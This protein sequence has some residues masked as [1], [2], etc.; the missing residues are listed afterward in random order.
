MSLE[1]SRRNGAY[2]SVIYSAQDGLEIARREKDTT[3]IFLG[4][5]FETTTPATALALKSA[6]AIGLKNFLVFSAHKVILPA[7]QV[8]LDDRE[9]AIDGFIAPGHVSVIIGSNAYHSIAA[10]YHRPCVAAGFDGQQMLLAMVEILVQLLNHQPKVESVYQDRIQPEGNIP[11][12]KIMDECFVSADSQWR[13]LGTIPNS[14]LRVNPAFAAFD[15]TKVFSLDEPKDIEPT[16]CRCGDVIKGKI[17]PFD[18][19][20]FGKQCNPQKPVGAC[21]V[22][23]EGSCSAYYRYRKREQNYE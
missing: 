3:V 4:I 5:G 6:Q 15:A 10:N 16:G 13:G 9:L 21:M 2:I 14:G 12:Q 8:L 7:M 1:D 23:R 22:S 19:P 11:A 17:S 18:C 20:L